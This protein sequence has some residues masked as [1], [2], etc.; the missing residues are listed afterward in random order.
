MLQP[1]L[2][3][4]V[5]AFFREHQIEYMITGSVVSSLQGEPRL[6]HDVD[7]VVQIDKGA[8]P[9]IVSAFSPPRYYVSESAIRDAIEHKT[10]FNLIDTSE[11]DKVDFWLLT[12]EPFD[13]SRFAR[14]KQEDLFGQLMSVSA[15]EDTILAKLKWAKMSGGSE[16]QFIDA[17][18]VYELQFT[19]LDFEYLEKWMEE[20]QLMDLWERLKKEAQPLS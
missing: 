10:M 13:C 17:L 8:I 1:E 16:K 4:K 2:L 12:N 9:H 5:L 6:T 18:R 15:P 19:G 7:I 11:N 14:R 3:T 20:L